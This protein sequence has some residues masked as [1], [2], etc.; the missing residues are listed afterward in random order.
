VRLWGVRLGAAGVLFAGILFGHFGIQIAHSL[1]EFVREFGLI[2]FVYSIGI[3]VGPGF[4]RSFKSMGLVLN[5]YAAGIVLGGVLVTLGIWGVAKVPLPVALGLLSGGVTNTPSLAAVQQAM[6]ELPHFDPELMKLPALGYALAYPFGIVGIILT[7][8]LTRVFFRID[9]GQEARRYMEKYAQSGVRLEAR[10]IRVENANLENCAVE[11]IPAL[12]ESHV[13]ISRI[14]HGSSVSVAL[15][16]S[17]LHVGDVIRAVGRPET[18]AQL[19][20]VVGRR[21]VMAEV[22]SKSKIRSR[23]ML[24]TRRELVG[25]TVE[26]IECYL[27]GVT[28]TRIARGELEFAADPEIEINFADTLM[29]VGEEEDLAKFSR[30]VGDDEKELNHPELIPIFVGIALG[31]LLGSVPVH[32][33]GMAA[34]V[35]L[36]LAGGPLVAAIVLGSMGR[37]G[38]LIW[39]LPLGANFMLREVGITLFLACV[40]LRSGDRFFSTLAE[41]QGLVWMACGAA[42]TFFPLL[43]AAAVARLRSRMNYLTLCGLLAGS[44]TDPPALAFANQMAPSSAQ[45]V[46]YAA[47]YPLVMILRVVS[48]QV[49]LFLLAGR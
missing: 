42:I 15:P 47:V 5:L 10:D 8:I 34:P 2:L 23:R 36:G 6:T 7:M 11:N 49:L 13:V 48:A 32:L 46:S 37:I 22:E 14:Q 30:V 18:L 28:I 4:F 41:G 26:E 9:P 43:I 24:V 33:P 1:S 29:I 31:I 39:Y 38:R 25:H 19:E 27:Y 17:V 35:K 21:A 12:R 44:M 45:V 16:H 20:R 40:G 3:Q